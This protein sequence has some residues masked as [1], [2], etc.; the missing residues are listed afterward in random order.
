ME[1]CVRHLHDSFHRLK[2]SRYHEGPPRDELRLAVVQ[3]FFPFP[4]RSK[5]GPFVTW[6]NCSGK[7][8]GRVGSLRR[9]RHWVVFRK[10]QERLAFIWSVVYHLFQLLY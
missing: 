2:I 5:Q 4:L 10:H 6:R 3:V 1:S 9:W 8:D 7:P